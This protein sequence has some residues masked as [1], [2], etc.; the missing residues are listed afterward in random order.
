MGTFLAKRI[1]S[2]RSQG[3]RKQMFKEIGISSLLLVA[4]AACGESSPA[5]T[6]G[7]GET[8]GAGG[9]GIATA[10][11]T[12]AGTTGTVGASGAPGTAGS[13]ATGSGGMSGSAGSGAGGSMT[14]GGSATADAAPLPDGAVNGVP[15]DYQGKPFK[16]LQ[17]PGNIHMADYDL[18]GVGVAY[19]HG[20]PND[21]AAGI[22]MND[23]CCGPG[24]GCDQRTDP[25]CPPYRPNNDNA[26]LCHMNVGEP[27]NTP[28]GQPYAPYYPYLCYMATGEWAKYT[29]QVTQAGTY[30]IG[31]AMAVPAGTSIALD[32][33][34]GVTTGTIA[35]P[36]SPTAMCMCPE[37]Y[38]SWETVSNIGTVTIPAAGTY[39][40]TMRLVS[41]QFNP[42]YFSFT[43][44]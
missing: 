1:C 30:A 23:W 32:F 19:C 10:G 8:G 27:D 36:T 43:K 25:A 3:R 29:V 4:A 44:M 24:K 20:N 7:T 18:G 34:N 39:V 9:N 5:T 13:G 33:G 41:Q 42:E 31:G 6:T 22:K 11:T 12:T 15:A 16:V 26:G 40:M 28:T 37:T 35:L 21:C 2:A 17:I 14:D 38:H